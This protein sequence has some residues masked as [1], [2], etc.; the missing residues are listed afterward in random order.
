MTTQAPDLE[1]F[2]IQEGQRLLDAMREVTPTVTEAV[3]RYIWAEGMTGL[4]MA[5]FAIGIYI[6]VT[7]QVL[8]HVEDDG[9]GGSFAR[10][11]V[12]VMGGISASLVVFINLAV[13]LPKV[14][15]PEGATVMAALR[16]I[17][18]GQ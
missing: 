6:F 3:V 14:L 13:N 16:A 2:A 7:R 11:M 5:A 4:V 9:D 8:K 15:A 1:T 18:G 12:M 17:G 10:W